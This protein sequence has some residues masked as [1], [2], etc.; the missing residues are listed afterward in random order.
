MYNHN[1]KGSTI[2]RIDVYLQEEMNDV[3]EDE[4]REALAV[5]LWR[6]YE[7]LRSGCWDCEKDNIVLPAVASISGGDAILKCN[8][9]QI[10]RN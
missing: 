10:W 2:Q 4:W 7:R 9:M 8:L 1:N 6:I 3:C 5:Q